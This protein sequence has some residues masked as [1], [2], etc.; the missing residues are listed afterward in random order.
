MKIVGKIKPLEKGSREWSEITEAAC[1]WRKASLESGQ[2]ATLCENAA[3]ELEIE[4]DQGLIV[5]L[6]CRIS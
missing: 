2:N 1:A 3:R 6:N 5:H 4:R